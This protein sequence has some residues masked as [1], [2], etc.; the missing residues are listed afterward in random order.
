MDQNNFLNFENQTQKL[1]NATAV[2]VLGIGSI[3]S[4]CCYGIISVILGIV[5]LYL[6]KKDAVLYNQ[7]PSLYTNYNNVKTGKILCIIG[8]VLGAI[9]LITTIVLIAVVG[10]DALQNPALMEERMRELLGS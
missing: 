2:L 10:M 8:I 4:C 6:A 5:G 7:N 3:I 1:P 9:Y